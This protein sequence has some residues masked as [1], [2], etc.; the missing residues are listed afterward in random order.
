[1]ISSINGLEYNSSRENLTISEYGRHIQKLIGKAKSIEDKEQRQ[2][3]VEAIIDLMHQMKPQHKNVE[4]YKLKLW[5]HLFRIAD[6]QL[7]VTP[8]EGV[9]TDEPVNVN[10]KVK[11]D[12]PQSEFRFRHYGNTIQLMVAKAIATE[13]KEKKENFTKVIA[14]YMKLAYKTW[15]KKHYVNDQVI[16]NDLVKLSKGELS[17][18]EDTLIYNLVSSAPAKTNHKNNKPNKGKRSN[19]RHSNNN[20]RDHNNKHRRRK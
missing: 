13:D 9:T 16:K 18:D 12:Y 4:E 15:N 17:L 1:M 7:D 5:R 8:P 10:K 11:I 6:Y 19:P 14:A 3:F 20:N 2:H